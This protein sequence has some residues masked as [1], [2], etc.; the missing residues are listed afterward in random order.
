M[1]RQWGDAAA[2]GDPR[3]G[4]TG[5]LSARNVETIILPTTAPVCLSFPLVGPEFLT[6]PMRPL[7]ESGTRFALV[8]SLSRSLQL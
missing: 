4:G 1:S 2:I 6:I 5:A 8:L 7:V 3:G